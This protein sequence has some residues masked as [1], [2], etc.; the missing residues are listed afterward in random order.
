MAKTATE[1]IDKALTLIDEQLTTFTQAASTEMTIREMAEELLPDVCRNL[2]KEL[3]YELKRYLATSAVLVEEVLSDGESQTNYIKKKVAFT[4]PS[5]F[6]ELVAL[7]LTVW[8]KPVTEYMLVDSPEYKRQNNPFTRSGK[9]NPSVALT[10]KGTGSSSRI[11][12]FS[13]HNADAKT[14]ALFEYVTFD[15]V[16]DDVGND[17]P[18]EIFDEITKALAS[19]LNV[20]KGRFKEGAIKGEEAEKAI[21]QHI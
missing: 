9:Q 14:V 15:N 5:D 8:A 19:E 21:V 20:I 3:P 12:C 1:I 18:D 16:P 6:W 17:W 13:V 2:V 4:T 10:N 11:E 7:R